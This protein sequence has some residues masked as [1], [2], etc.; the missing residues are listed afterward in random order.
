MSI[1]KFQ[2]IM[3]VGRFANC[4]D[5]GPEFGKWNLIYAGNGLGKTTICAILRSLQSGDAVC[6]EERRTLPTNG[7][8]SISVLLDD[9]IV[10]KYRKQKWDTLVSNI[11]I[12]DANFVSRNVSEGEY[13]TR[14]QRVNSLEVIIGSQGVELVNEFRE[15]VEK[16]K[17][18][19]KEIRDSERNIG[20]IV[21]G[22]V[23]VEEFVN[24]SKETDIDGKIEENET[25]LRLAQQRDSIANASGLE[26]I[27]TPVLPADTERLIGTKLADMNAD[28]TKL[29]QEH[30]ETHKTEEGRA[31]VLEGVKYVSERTERCPFCGQSATTAP[32]IDIYKEILTERYETLV[33]ELEELREEIEGTTGEAIVHDIRSTAKG[34]Q[35]SLQV[36]KPYLPSDL[37]ELPDIRSLDG[38]LTRL[39]RS[40]TKLVNHKKNNPLSIVSLDSDYEEARTNYD[41][42]CRQLANYN[43]LVDRINEAVGLIKNKAD[44]ADLPSIEHDKRLLTL[45][46]QRFSEPTRELCDKH[47]DLLR[48]KKEVDA[49]KKR[50]RAALDKTTPEVIN[51][52][53]TEINNMLELFGAHFRIT[54]ISRIDRG[55]APSAS[56][57]IL[58]NE[59]EVDVDEGTNS[60][61]VH[62]FRTV[63]SAGDKSALALAFFLAQLIHHEDNISDMVLVLDDPLSSMDNF[64][65]S[66]TVQL[67]TEWGSLCKQVLVFSHDLRFLQEVSESIAKTDMKTIKLAHDGE[68]ETRICEWNMKE[69]LES[70]IQRNY[71]VLA[72]YHDGNHGNK[73]IV[74]QSLRKYWEAFLVTE[75]PSD[76]KA[77]MTFGTMIDQVK[78]KRSNHKLYGFHRKLS[79][80][81]RFARFHCHGA[82]PGQSIREEI[83]AGELRS[84]VEWTIKSTQNQ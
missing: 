76:F 81:N 39:N 71:C 36:W 48:Q 45:R 75:Y 77:G 43:E 42:S 21:N 49:G 79:V 25:K 2:S 54:S 4:Q 29:L 51:T 66:A 55:D 67:L 84:L 35:S 60:P 18:I 80:I 6:V 68:A 46:K 5:Q 58:L 13:V 3:N 64:R 30:L 72:E 34:N 37:R 20:A 61:G 1:K 15:S 62:G 57:K 56:Y 41:N 44:S 65:R 10:A 16:G 38:S 14:E 28:A 22:L 52:F 11:A 82:N 19:N 74:A 83:D 73:S 53:Q 69:E 26:S 47:L 8:V 24:W 70:E 33:K 50:E 12:F 7:D 17:T 32:L 63:L 9:D 78:S 59:C 31:W 27:S 23:S 40:L